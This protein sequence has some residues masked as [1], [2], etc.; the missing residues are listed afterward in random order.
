M[1]NAARHALSMDTWYRV[2][3]TKA[4]GDALE[5]TMAAVNDTLPTTKTVFNLR[6][7]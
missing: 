3:M 1:D 4:R 5:N 2:G 6:R 7:H